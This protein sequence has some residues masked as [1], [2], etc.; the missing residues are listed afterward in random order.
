M[1][2]SEL[3]KIRYSKTTW[4]TTIVV[5]LGAAVISFLTVFSAEVIDS[6][7]SLDSSGSAAGATSELGIVGF[8][9]A[10]MQWAAV[11]IVGG[12][13]ASVSLSVIGLVIFGL[14]NVT[15]EFRYGSMST[16]LLARPSRTRAM[17]AKA[18][19]IATA[20]VVI[21]IIQV[22]VT[23]GAL[24]S[25]LLFYDVPL[26]ISVGALLAN[27]GLQIAALAMLALV[28]MGLG[29]VVRSQVAGLVI[30]FAWVLAES[31]IRSVFG[32]LISGVTAANFLPFGLG[33]DF[34]LHTPALA[35]GG[36]AE[37]APAAAATALTV[38]MVV[39]VGAGT[40]TLR[41][42]DVPA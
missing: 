38:W 21:S 18:G 10:S 27:W 40:L 2:A 28:G 13:G 16:T 4:I 39:M 5:T 8:G 20:A 6:L 26:A 30:V 15:S 41:R 17:F 19:A 36:I 14:L 12:S 33:S 7:S 31:L 42:R 1:Y 23:A 35:G 3:A 9:H 32:A 34:N 37:L 25:G 22:I 11:N 29:L 24:T